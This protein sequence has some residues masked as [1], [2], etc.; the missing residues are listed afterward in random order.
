L[1]DGNVTESGVPA[2]DVQ[3]GGQRWRA[4]IDTGFNGELELPEL[5]SSRKANQLTQVRV[6]QSIT[7]RRAQGP[8]G[9]SR[10]AH[11]LR[12]TCRIPAV[13]PA[14]LTSTGLAP[15][16][17]T[18]DR[19]TRGPRDLFFSAGFIP[20]ESTARWLLRRDRSSNPRA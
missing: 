12:A 4:I 19:L 11:E 18:I 13:I 17:G 9:A 14:V 5:L 10:H 15:V 2:I 8:D 3:H 7:A 20:V 16:A 6:A 1:I